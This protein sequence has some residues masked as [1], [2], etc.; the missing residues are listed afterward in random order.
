MTT[1][2]KLFRSS[3]GYISPY[4]V[5]DV[6]GNLITKTL[7]IT[8]RRLELTSGTSLSY[9]GVDLL[10]PTTLGSS[11]VNILGT[12]TGLSVSGTVSLTGTGTISLTPTGTVT[13]TP[14]VT[15]NIDNV[16]IGGTTPRTG[17][18]TTL[19]TINDVVF[20]GTGNISFPTSGS[21]TI[22]PL[23]ALIIGTAGSTN[24]LIGNISAIT[25]NQVINFSP[26]GTGTIT[27]NPATTGTLDNVVIGN[28]IAR[29]G[30][31]TNV[32]LNSSDEQWGSNRSQAVT[33]R[34]SE[35]STM[36]AYFT[37]S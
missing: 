36:I 18:F 14:T 26:L 28:T 19:Q 25:T 31:F 3:H 4:F 8:G 12:L 15:G 17:K 27:I 10:S 32:T 22:A 20:D 37:G 9:N 2:A 1:A 23:G 6:E 30:K 34:Y 24:S 5:V 21:V 33:K 7:T 29:A 35:N 16:N 11:V 13:I